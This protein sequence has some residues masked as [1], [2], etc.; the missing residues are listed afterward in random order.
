[1]LQAL[2]NDN[3]NG[4]TPIGLDTVTTPRLKGGK[5]NPHQGRVRKIMTGANV[6]VF[7]NKRVHGYDAMVKRR[8]VGEGKNPASFVLSPRKW[9]SRI[10]NT[11]FVSHNGNIYL[12]VIF[13]SAG[14]V[15]YTLDGNP[16]DRDDIEGLDVNRKE[17]AQGG[18][19]DKVIIRTFKAASI[20]RVTINGTTENF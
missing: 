7:Q 9:G 13:L 2:V 14:T 3:V 12:E 5:S 10:P 15:S 11:P 16:I 6:M 20:N 18:L 8:L 1:M 4:M 19:H 17:A